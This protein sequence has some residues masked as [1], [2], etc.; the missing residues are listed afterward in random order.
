MGFWGFVGRVGSIL[1]IMG[2]SHVG[3]SRMEGRRAGNRLG[4]IL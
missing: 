2:L 1:R 4:P 3:G